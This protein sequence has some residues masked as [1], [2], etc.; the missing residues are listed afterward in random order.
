[1]G[2]PR[3]HPCRR[4][5]RTPSGGTS[6]PRTGLQTRPSRPATKTGGP[7]RDGGPTAFWATVN[8]DGTLLTDISPSAD[9][10]GHP[11][12]PS[13]SYRVETHEYHPGSS[14]YAL[15]ESILAY[16]RRH[17]KAGPFLEPVDPVALNLPDYFDVIK[18]PMDI[19]T[20]ARR[21][22]EGHYGKAPAEGRGGG[23]RDGHA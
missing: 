19:S 9:A 8:D 14:A 7:A 20:V 13:G 4:R 15:C 3:A 22:E 23:G 10:G 17:P 11:A 21:L 5:R 1:L 16:L 6:R 18:R 12:P 2:P